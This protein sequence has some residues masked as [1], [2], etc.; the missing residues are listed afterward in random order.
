[1]PKYAYSLSSRVFYPD[2]MAGGQVGMRERDRNLEENVKKMLDTLGTD[3][4]KQVQYIDRGWKV[5]RAK[6]LPM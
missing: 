1:M 6:L 2:E 3:T 5:C 4:V